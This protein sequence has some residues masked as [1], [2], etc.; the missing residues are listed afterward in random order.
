MPWK[1]KVTDDVCQIH[2]TTTDHNST[3]ESMCHISN[4]R[5]WGGLKNKTLQHS[6]HRQ[7]MVDLGNPISATRPCPNFVTSKPSPPPLE[8]CMPKMRKVRC[9][10]ANAR[11]SHV[12]TT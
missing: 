10:K 3:T 8:P 5:N 6:S 11:N 1:Y 12:N 2:S 9:D 4:C 7:K